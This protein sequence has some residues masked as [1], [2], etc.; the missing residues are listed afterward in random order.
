V[1]G[2]WGLGK[3]LCSL[4]SAA[5]AIQFASPTRAA[6]IIP[7][8]SRFVIT[9][10]AQHNNQQLSSHDDEYNAIDTFASRVIVFHGDQQAIF[11]VA[12]I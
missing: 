5:L 4:I 1:G 8:K 6:L 2:C 12:H 3:M 7:D 11:T 9:P 10:L